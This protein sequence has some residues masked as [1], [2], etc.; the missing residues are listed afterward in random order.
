M[1]N[2]IKQGITILL[3]VLLVHSGSLPTARAFTI[4]EE[5]ELGE[6]L[7]YQVRS[8]FPIIGDP[9][10]HRYINDLGQEVLD[11]AGIQF[12]E[13][14]FFIVK[15]KQFNAFAAPSGLIFFYTE[16]IQSMDSEDELVSVIAHE[17]GHVAKRHLASRMKK[18][19]IVNIA[20]LGAA[21][22]AIALGGGGAASQA[23][24]TG[25]LAAGQSAQLYFSRE[26]EK[27]ADLLAY[28]WLKELG[29]NPD[30]Q[31]KMLQTMRRITR[32]RMGQV[33]QYLLTHPDPEAR[34]DYV[35]SLIAAEGGASEAPDQTK[36]FSFLRFKYRIMAL[37]EDNA[38]AKAYFANRLNDS[39][40]T[41]FSKTMARYGLS[42]IFRRENNYEQA[43]SLLNEVI[44]TLP[45]Q[46]I[47][48]VDQAIILAEQGDFEQARDLLET[49]LREQPTDMYTAFHLAG[50]LEKIGELERA[51]YL[52]RE[53]VARMP[54]FSS[55]F[56]DLGRILSH[57]GKK[58]EARF[59]LG[60]FNLYEGKLDLAQANFK[61]VIGAPQA[62]PAIQR[63]SEAMLE[64]IERLKKG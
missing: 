36:D 30:G 22:A 56:F 33:P 7:L 55:A 3:V 44:A 34:L 41:S 12:F 15:S 2:K 19:T 54:E 52:L 38:A 50:V 46:R 29:R 1:R 27:E 45:R 49:A 53:V 31:R 23:L 32:Y 47:L 37:V 57:Q 17:I 63:E 20:A 59:F 26:D 16:L 9:D 21:L 39:R 62:D 43:L 60:K 24:L 64:L 25:S 35:E 10:L 8:A 48:R 13:Y 4:G 42:Q 51:E 6:K 40:S 11:V 61:E 18:G 14:R 5:R 58:A 28:H